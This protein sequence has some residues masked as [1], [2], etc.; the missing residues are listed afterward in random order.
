MGY[1]PWRYQHLFV[2]KMSVGAPPD[3]LAPEGQNWGFQPL[4]PTALRQHGY[5]YVRDY[6]IQQMGAA[7][8][9][10]IDHAIGLHRLFWIPEGGTGCD[11]VFVRQPSEELYAILSLESHRAESVLIGENLGLVPREVNRGMARHGIGGMYVQE[12]ELTGDAKVPLGPPK[13]NSIA[14]FGTHDMAP[15]AAFWTDADL[16]QRIAA[17][18]M[19]S[20]VAGRMAG[21]RV[22]GKRAL[23]EHLKARGLLQDASSAREA[24]RGSTRLLAESRARW[25]TVSLEDA[26]GET[27]P[28]NVPGTDATQNPNWTRR[29]KYVLEQFDQ[30]EDITAV[31]DV[32]RS[33]RGSEKEEQNAG[34]G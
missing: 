13:R 1:D 28:Q 20:A 17:G 23:A 9:L 19:D 27:R 29:A 15:F 16:K 30:L 26:W 21:E 14:S 11:G 25:T 7:G 22:K 24:Y 32:M 6:L 5:E 8:L 3:L 18:I 31:T 33:V 2:E 4:N 12:F 10:R 34:K